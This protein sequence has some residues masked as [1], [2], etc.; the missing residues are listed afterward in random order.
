MVFVC[1]ANGK[2]VPLDPIAPV[3]VRQGDGEGG[4][5]WAQDTSK[6]I[7]VSHFATCSKA[8]DFSGSGRLK[9]EPIT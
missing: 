6:E 9:R 8:N 5:I 3:Y 2:T 7:L 4:A 1:T